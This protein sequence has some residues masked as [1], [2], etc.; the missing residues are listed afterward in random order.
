MKEGD[1]NFFP[2]SIMRKLLALKEDGISQ[3]IDIFPVLLFVNLNTERNF[4]YESMLKVLKDLGFPFEAEVLDLYPDFVV[5]CFDIFRDYG[6]EVQRALS[7][8]NQLI[9]LEF[10]KNVF[11]T[12]KRGFFRYINIKDQEFILID[13]GAYTEYHHRKSQ[14]QEKGIFIDENVYYELYHNVKVK[15]ITDMVLKV[16]SEREYF[17]PYLRPVFW[18]KNPLMGIGERKIIV[19][20]GDKGTGKT[21]FSLEFLRNGN[22]ERIAYV[23][24]S[25]YLR[26]MPYSGIDELARS[27]E[28]YKTNSGKSSLDFVK[29]LLTEDIS[30]CI[31][32]EDAEYIDPDSKKF[33]EELIPLTPSHTIFLFEGGGKWDDETTLQIDGYVHSTGI[34]ILKSLSGGRRPD[35]TILEMMNSVDNIDYQFI[36]DFF[37]IFSLKKYFIFGEDTFYLSPAAHTLKVQFSRDI[38]YKIL[39]DVLKESEKDELLKISLMQNRVILNEHSYKKLSRLIRHGIV[40]IHGNHLI[41]YSKEIAKRFLSSG[42]RDKILA[43]L[44]NEVSD[45]D[46]LLRGYVLSIIGEKRSAFRVFKKYLKTI[47]DGYETKKLILHTLLDFE[48]TEVEK[49]ELL[50]ALYN[51]EK[52]TESYNSALLHLKNAL[53]TA[54]SIGDKKIIAQVLYALG[55]HN[56]EIG[57]NGAAIMNFKDAHKF[58]KDAQDK[59][60]YFSILIELLEFYRKREDISKLD[61]ILQEFESAL[62]DN[63]D[64][65]PQMWYYK[66]V[67]YLMKENLNKA[68]EALLDAYNTAKNIGQDT[69]TSYILSS[70]ARCEF[71]LGQ[72]RIAEKYAEDAISLNP[73]NMEAHLIF[74]RTKFVDRKVEEA[75]KILKEIPKSDKEGKEVILDFSALCAYKGKYKDAIKKLD[76]LLEKIKKLAMHN[77][78]KRKARYLLRLGLYAEAYKIVNDMKDEELN[79]EFNM[80]LLGSAY[81]PEN[82]TPYL[83]YVAAF[84]SGLKREQL[85][86]SVINNYDY[87]DAECMLEF[88]RAVKAL[89]DGNLNIA[90]QI[91]E[92]MKNMYF[93]ASLDIN[94]AKY[95]SDRGGDSNNYFREAGEIAEKEGYLEVLMWLYLILGK[96]DKAKVFFDRMFEGNEELKDKYIKVREHIFGKM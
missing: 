60:I 85:D 10:V 49:V 37:T 84:T 90:Y 17:I 47:G 94:I 23:K 28:F 25:P 27:M 86:T 77:I 83:K 2:G 15:P 54:K 39:F 5:M 35:K 31:F 46:L 11:I 58:A 44:E 73:A 64:Y 43:F 56:T 32:F 30:T 12:K 24:L 74:S 26:Y 79:A 34:S 40:G 53:K 3:D 1:F 80:F 29:D 66:G 36:Y 45:T 14:I 38:V 18:G 69:L 92:K 93:K 8:A 41:L 72:Y 63:Q 16:E 96:K 87:I 9:D 19:I 68:H 21:R 22:F 4:T 51:T 7:L 42:F 59:D 20:R 71:M 50:M 76:E 82:V 55:K 13:A 67:Y 88:G 89:L 70:L 61:E 52:E 57:Q 33:L 91:K 78:L 62:G 6:D 75:C 81:N 48:P 65:R 95:I